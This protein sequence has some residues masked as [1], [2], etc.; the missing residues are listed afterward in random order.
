MSDDRQEIAEKMEMALAEL[1]WSVSLHVNETGGITFTK[2]VPQTDE[3][4]AAFYMAGRVVNPADMP[5]WSCWDKGGK[6]SSNGA[7]ATCRRGMCLSPD[8]PALPPRE[9][10][11]G[12]P[13]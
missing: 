2:E 7:A 1:G 13:R 9:L 6:I 8:G 4:L 10:L 5:C 12:A 3:W 11:I